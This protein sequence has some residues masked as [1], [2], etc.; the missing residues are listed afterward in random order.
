MGSLNARR[1]PPREAQERTP[2]GADAAAE[3]RWEN[4]GGRLPVEQPM[5]DPAGPRGLQGHPRESRG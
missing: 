5:E 4:E 3:R 2:N 1:P